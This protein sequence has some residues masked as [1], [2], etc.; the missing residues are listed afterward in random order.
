MRVCC[1]C[2]LPEQRR[3]LQL[4]AAQPEV[5]EG[6]HHKSTGVSSASP[7]AAGS[8]RRG[9][10]RYAPS[11]RR[12]RR[13]RRGGGR[14]PPGERRDLNE[15]LG[16]HL[17]GRGERVLPR[18]DAAIPALLRQARPRSSRRPSRG[19]R[20]ARRPSARTSSRARSSSD[21]I[22]A[23]SAPR[24]RQRERHRRALAVRAV[25]LPQHAQRVLRPARRCHLGD[26]RR[27]ERRRPRRVGG[28]GGKRRVVG[29][30]GGAK[31]LGRAGFDGPA[32]E[33]G[34][35]SVEFRRARGCRGA[36]QGAK[37]RRAIISSVERHEQLERRAVGETLLEHVAHRDPG[38]R[39]R[40][41]HQEEDAEAGACVIARCRSPRSGSDEICARLK[42]GRRHRCAGRGARGRHG[43][44]RGAALARR[45]D[46]RLGGHQDVERMIPSRRRGS[47]GR[48]AATPP[49]AAAR[50]LTRTGVVL[51]RGAWGRCTPRSKTNGEVVAVK[52]MSVGDVFG[53][54]SPTSARGR[55]PAAAART[56]CACSRCSTTRGTAAHV[57][58]E[59]CSES[60][61]APTGRKQRRPRVVE[62]ERGYDERR[63]TASSTSCCAGV[64]LPPT[65][66]SATSS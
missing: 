46:E 64:V 5:E 43:C 38:V 48:R 24:A 12:G 51:G 44:R 7:G 60:S 3:A 29:G 16:G 63:V 27:L 15:A 32:D 56:S 34:G 37:L 65:A 1:G 18:D 41:V 2:C 4:A 66:S 36:A 57:V 58:M 6:N 52:T 50:P 23:T 59:L 13:R 22:C 55:D 9:P 11:G 19:G 10:S 62:R 17:L 26:A 49:T 20:R 30:L 39:H 33:I 31:R 45:R 21:S 54:R 35:G 28:R 53:S 25:G 47:C 61:S 8:A 42:S 14:A 40:V